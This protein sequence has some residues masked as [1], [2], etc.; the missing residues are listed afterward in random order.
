[1][2]ICACREAEA[3]EDGA[4]SGEMRCGAPPSGRLTPFVWLRWCFEKLRF[5]GRRRG[6]GPQVKERPE[7]GFPP[8]PLGRQSQK[9]APG[10]TGDAP[11][12]RKEA[13]AESLG[14]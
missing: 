8:G 10:R 11:G 13:Q 9:R 7:E 1:M 4:L 14:G 2:Q 5:L 6:Q 12:Q 3:R